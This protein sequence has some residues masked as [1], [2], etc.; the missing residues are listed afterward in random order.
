VKDITIQEY[1]TRVAGAVEPMQT[2]LK[3]LGKA[4]GYKGLRDRITA[5]Q[6]ATGQS[7]TALRGITPPPIIAQE[8]TS[9]LTAIWQAR[10]DLGDIGDE[11]GERKLCTGLAVRA[12]VGDDDSTTALRT[13]LA[14]V[15]AKLPAGSTLELSLPAARQKV[16]S[17][18]SN[19][20]FIRSGDRNGRGTFTI[21]NGGSD[22][23]LIA[24][25]KGKKTFISV[26]V[27]HGKKYKVSGIPD[28]NYT[29]FFSG[30]A[31]WDAKARAFAEDCEFE[32]Y[33]DPIDYR[34]TTTATRIQWQ[35]WTIELDRLGTGP[36]PTSEV[37]PGDF[38]ES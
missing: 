11:V 37:D 20:T 33:N 32:R 27:R 30:G 24:L 8:H 10:G 29:I 31:A 1:A 38:P 13:A 22:D 35:T 15:K 5:V 19:G 9:L 16:G 28:G 12:K 14:A 6:V 36:D 25:R 23:A 2:A 34:T 17:R 21:D 4:K 18:P 3:G 26:Y 7:A